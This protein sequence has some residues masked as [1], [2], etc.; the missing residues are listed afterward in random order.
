[1]KSK[2]VVVTLCWHD[3]PDKQIP[4]LIELLQLADKCSWGAIDIPCKICVE[5]DQFIIKVEKGFDCLTFNIKDVK[6]VLRT[7]T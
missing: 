5:D 2:T 3:N 7:Q 4:A 1:M 6:E